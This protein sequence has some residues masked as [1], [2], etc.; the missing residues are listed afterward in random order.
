MKTFK[1]TKAAIE[2]LP[3]AP[4]G[5]QVDYYDAVVQGLRL[6]VGASGIKS[7]CVAKKKEGR[8]IRATLGRYPSMTID[9]AR[10]KA[11]ETLG[12]VTMTGQNPNVIRREQTKLN[13]TLG[14]A[15]DAYLASRRDKI[16]SDT[17]K[18]YRADLTNY[19]GDWMATSLIKL[20]RE[21]VEVRHKAITEGLPEGWHGAPLESRKGGTGKG[22]NAQADRWARTLRAVWKFARDHYRDAEDRV[23]L[24]EPPTEVLSSKRLWHDAPRKNDR[25][26]NH[27]LK[28][29]LDAVERIRQQA[30]DCRDDTAAAV[31]DAIDIALF[32]GLRRTELFELTWERVNLAGG[33]F[34]ID[35]TKNGDLLELPITD[36]LLTIF[37]RRQSE[38]RKQSRF[39]FPGRNPDR[40][41][42]EPRRVIARICAATV[43]NPNPN[44]LPPLEFTCH[45]ARRTFGTVA[46]LAEVGQYTI[47]R[48][49]NHRT[50]R[51]ADVTQGYIHF[52]ADELRKPATRIE[53][54]I[55][56]YA[57]RLDSANNANSNLLTIFA[58]LPEEE[59]RRL[60]LSLHPSKT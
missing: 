19:S 6:R 34:W 44:N 25:I 47:K 32:T 36:T 48:L 10:A 43:P 60:L 5:K 35:K 7:F 17:A 8:F 24:P 40:P 38:N 59:Q 39:V 49:M 12:E 18:H 53:Q 46:E 55:L 56:K 33:Y 3:L 20:N 27:E 52:T 42:Q 30:L 28:R 11:L 21:R 13:I 14:E 51:S 50:Q 45:D 15:V 37:R 23:M 26:R 54:E 1:F 9:M 22:S 58:T 2:A 16:K 31:C 29:W 4:A 57:G 41:I